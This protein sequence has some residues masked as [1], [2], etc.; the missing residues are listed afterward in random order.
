MRNDIG[1]LRRAQRVFMANPH[2]FQSAQEIA[3]ET[4]PEL[5][6]EVVE[7]FLEQAPKY[8]KRINSGLKEC[9]PVEVFRAAHTLK[10][11]CGYLGMKEMVRLCENLESWSNQ[12]DKSN[13]AAHVLY[14]CLQKEFEICRQELGAVMEEIGPKKASYRH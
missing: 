11:S 5:L 9:E 2:I 8:I 7:L 1:L 14:Q 10:S 4:S 12:P 13:L 6:G 3:S